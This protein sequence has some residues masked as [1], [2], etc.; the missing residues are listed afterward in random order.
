MGKNNQAR[1]AAKAKARARQRASQAHAGAGRRGADSWRDAEHPG[2]TPF[3]DDAQ[4]AELA[5][6]NVA[7]VGIGRHGDPETALT[8]LLELPFRTT[9][10]VAERLL[11]EHIDVLWRHGW[12]PEELHRQARVGAV[13][14]AA[15]R[16]VELAVRTACASALDQDLDPSWREQAERLRPAGAVA[17]RGWLRPAE[18][19]TAD[20]REWCASVADAYRLLVGLPPLDELLPP[21][22][23]ATGSRPR[24]VTPAAA[25]ADPVL[26]RVRNL[27]A[28]AESTDFEAEAIALTAKAQELITRHAID[29]AVLQDQTDATA[30]PSMVRVPIDAP[31][32]DAK[33]FLLQTVASH[34]RCRSVFSPRVAMST[35]VG[36]PADLAAVEVLFTSL[37]VQA[38]QAL[39]EAGR[40]AKPGTRTRSQSYRSAFLLAYTRR[41]G[42]RLAEI[43]AHVFAAA[44]SDPGQFLPVLRSQDET[45]EEFMGQRFGDLYSSAVRGGYDPAGWSGGRMAADNARLTAADLEPAEDP[46]LF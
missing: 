29:T 5:W 7:N 30:E 42:D 14:G 37:L 38:Q 6:A 33:S 22:G 4:L 34:S 23:A 39:A 1:R 16:M 31:Y 26:N 32:A 20:R 27:L 28:K 21:P 40:T 25:A 9:A 44:G 35:V 43:N 45:I 8:R 3:F 24:R 18:M 13:P 11:L 10:D 17:R 41:I 36:Y 46:A 2:S 12:Q 15:T 19:P